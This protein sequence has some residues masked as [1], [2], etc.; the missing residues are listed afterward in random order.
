MVP[1]I[2]CFKLYLQ[3]KKHMRKYSFHFTSVIVFLSLFQSSEA[4]LATTNVGGSSMMTVSARGGL[5][6]PNME[7]VDGTPYLDNEFHSASVRTKSGF[8]TSGVKVKFNAYG[9]EIIFLQDGIELA[10]DDFEMVSYPKLQ[11]GAISQVVFK[12][13]FPK[14]DNLNDNTV[15]QVLA[16]GSKIYLLKH[17][18]K[19]LEDLKTMGD[20]NR[21]EFVTR[22]QLYI[23][24]PSLG[25][26]KIKADKKALIALFP[27]LTEKIESV[28]EEKGLSI[29]K[30]NNLITLIE[31]L[32]KP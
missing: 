18:S 16:S 1:D 21:K 8:D 29:R 22:E 14:I 15:Y 7:N 28:I 12:T 11:N 25:I 23:Y 10:L 3:A 31:E 13:G 19:K 32:N 27:E 30:E 26:K 17:I 5:R 2:Y 6:L 4:Q 20:Y 9:N 24:S